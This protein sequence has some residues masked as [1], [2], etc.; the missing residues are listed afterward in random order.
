MQGEQ[1]VYLHV[2]GHKTGTTFLQNVL[3]RNR[4]KL[5]R[6][7]LLYPGSRQAAHVWANLDLRGATFKGYRAPQVRGAWQQLVEEVAAWDGPAVIDHEMFSLATPQQIARAMEDLSFAQVDV[8]FTA[9]DMARQLPAA[10]QEWV[11]NGDTLTFSE[12]LCAVRQDG[13]QAHRLWSMHDVPAILAKWSSGLPPAQVH[14][15]TVPPQGAEPGML[16]RRFA[17]VLGIEPERY[18]TDVPATN[19]SLGA[20]EVTVIRRMNEQLGEM[21]WPR[22]GR[23]VKHHLAGALARRGG[24]RIELPQD[25]FDW[26]IEQGHR[27]VGAL[28]AAGYDVVGDLTELLPGERPTGVDPD[29]APDADLAAAAI[30]GLA[31]VVQRDA[32]ASQRA[33]ADLR[34][35]RARLDQAERR[36]AQWE[37][38]S[39]G[40]LAKRAAVDLAREIEWLRALYHRYRALRR[41]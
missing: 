34:R 14:V 3:W 17:Q 25:A 9:R 24:A 38:R 21:P 7:R 22:Y 32:G 33:E 40:Q 18:R 11:K 8:V 27:M 4:G 36:L 6:D 19:T 35:V 28:T 29:E 10:W 30:T 5:K 1:V 15:V 12:F 31:A 39:P 13:A 16:W 20:V 41:P 37:R 23:L 2:G 26:A